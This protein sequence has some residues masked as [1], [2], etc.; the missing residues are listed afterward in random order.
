MSINFNQFD[1]I[2]HQSII[3]NKFVLIFFLHYTINFTFESS[4]FKLSSLLFDGYDNDY[5]I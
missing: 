1:S 3:K 2:F 5:E 4:I